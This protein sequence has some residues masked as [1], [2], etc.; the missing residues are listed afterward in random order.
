MGMGMGN[1]M[2]F[3]AA[4]AYKSERDSLLLHDHGSPMDH[5]ELK[6]LG[7]KIPVSK[8]S[9]KAPEP[10]QV[11]STGDAKRSKYSKKRR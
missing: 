4:K 2:A 6:L 5:V 9:I 7:D 10:K 1:N 11:P 3:D 8:P